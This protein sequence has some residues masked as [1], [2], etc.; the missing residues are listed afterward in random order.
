MP[1]CTSAK[2]SWAFPVG[3]IWRIQTIQPRIFSHQRS[4]VQPSRQTTEYRAEHR[5]N[6]NEIGHG[7]PLRIRNNVKWWAFRPWRWFLMIPVNMI[8]YAISRRFKKEASQCLVGNSKK[9]TGMLTVLTTLTTKWLDNTVIEIKALNSLRYIFGSWT[10]Q[11]FENREAGIGIIMTN[12]LKIEL[13][14]SRG[15]MDTEQWMVHG[16]RPLWCV[17]L[18]GLEP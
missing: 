11:R 15:R 13:R 1:A 4:P 3:E 17:V 14:N 2:S 16:I 7:V 9:N 12:F 18:K 6:S 10:V 8:D 5:N